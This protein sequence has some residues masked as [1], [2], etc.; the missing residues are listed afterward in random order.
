M[1][2]V[3][4]RSTDTFDIFSDWD[5]HIDSQRDF[6][7]IASKLAVAAAW[8]VIRRGNLCIVTLLDR[9]GTLWDYSGA[10]DRFTTEWDA[11]GTPASSDQPI[12]DYWIMAFKNLKGIY[13][14]FN[15]FV[16]LGIE[17]STG[18]ARDLYLQRQYN[19]AHYKNFFAYKQVAHLV[20]ADQHLKQVAGLPY[21]TANE[22]LLKLAALNQLIL[23]VSQTISEDSYAAFQDKVQHLQHQPR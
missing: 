2:L 9:S 19:I 7:A 5:F 1:K 11:L 14:G 16:S 12:Y 6:E 10:Y 4:S 20:E 21:A 22:Q 18:L 8:S 13:R 3:G 15:A 17:M 23:S